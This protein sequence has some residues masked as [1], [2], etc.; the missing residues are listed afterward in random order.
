MCPRKEG[1]NK[2]GEAKA[3]LAVVAENGHQIDPNTSDNSI[4]TKKRPNAI[5]PN[6][7]YIHTFFNCRTGNQDEITDS[8]L[9]QLGREYIKWAREYDTELGVPLKQ[10]FWLDHGISKINLQA[11]RKSLPELNELVITGDEYCGETRERIIRKYYHGIWARQAVYVSDYMAHDEHM[12][13]VRE[14]IKHQIDKEEGLSPQQQQALFMSFM[15][16]YLN[17][18]SDAGK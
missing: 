4:K 7:V 11:F 13:E 5:S 3:I 2:S 10:T 8:Q 6:G 1:S 15:E 18:K 9:I 16:P 14:R 12:I 17:K